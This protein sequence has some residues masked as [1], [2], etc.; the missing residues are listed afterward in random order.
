MG[1]LGRQSR[2]QAC[3]RTVDRRDAQA[4]AGGETIRKC[5]QLLV[6]VTHR[7]VDQHLINRNPVTGVR[8]PRTM[9]ERYLLDARLTP[10]P[11]A[12]GPSHNELI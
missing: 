12:A 6:S 8:M 7:A 1:R 4:G 10:E 3:S 11:L 2:H 9:R 5:H